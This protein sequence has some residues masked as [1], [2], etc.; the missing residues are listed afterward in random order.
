VAAAWKSEKRREG[1]QSLAAVI[2]GAVGDGKKLE[3]GALGW[4]IKVRSVSGVR[5]HGNQQEK[6]GN[7][8][9]QKVFKLKLGEAA[10]DR[11]GDGY[12]IAVLK[13]IIP[14]PVGPSENK[15][16]VEAQ[17]VQS[18][19]NDLNSQLVAGFRKNVGVSINRRAI[20]VLFGNTETIKVQ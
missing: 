12:E 15:K 10:M 4:N 5:R 20:D 14:A 16:K 9:A 6:I 18:I 3:D 7:K 2:V 8:L 11:A 19:R 17:I 13:K 1:A